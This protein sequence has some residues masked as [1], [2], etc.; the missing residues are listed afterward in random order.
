MINKEIITEL[1]RMLG[2]TEITDIVKDNARE[3]K[4]QA[5]ELKNMSV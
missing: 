3:M 2:G 4:K 1:S 5:D